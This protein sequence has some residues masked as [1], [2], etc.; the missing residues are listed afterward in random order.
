MT[1]TGRI[2]EIRGNLVIVSPDKSAACFGCMNM[3]CK[4]G[5]LITAENPLALP[6]EAGLMVEVKAPPPFILFRQ[7]LA[8]FL[9]PILGFLAGLT[10]TRLFFPGAGEAAAI[11]AGFFLLFAAAFV[12]FKIRR[13][14]GAAG[15]FTVTKV[16]D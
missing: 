8:A 7:A 13:K 11:S 6:L 12:V 2:R 1:E 5:G 10:L 3:E 4:A 14:S 9:P 16:A 15:N